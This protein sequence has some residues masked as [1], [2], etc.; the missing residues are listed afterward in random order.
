MQGIVTRVAHLRRLLRY[1]TVD[2]E[3]HSGMRITEGEDEM[4]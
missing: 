3:T 1:P 4:V 2:T